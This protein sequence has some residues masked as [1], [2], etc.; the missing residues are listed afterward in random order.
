MW[1]TDTCFYFA[2]RPDK[3]KEEAMREGGRE[4]KGGG[5]SGSF[6]VGS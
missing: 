4:G 1:L 3:T 5:G 2:T 6:G